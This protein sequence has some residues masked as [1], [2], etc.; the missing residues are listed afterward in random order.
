MPLNILFIS[1]YFP[2]EMGAPAARTYELAKHWVRSGHSVTVL[3]AF[4]HHP[5]GVIPKEYRK[6]IFLRERVE[7]IQV[8]R[9]F[10]YAT[11]NKGFLKRTLSYLSFMS[12]AILFSPLVKGPFQVVVAT[13][14]QFFVAVAGCFISRLKRRPFIFEVRDLWPESIVAVGALRNPAIIRLLTKIEFFLYTKASLIVGVAES[15]RRILVERGIPSSKIEIVPNG[16]D[17]DLFSHPAEGM[18]VRR[19]HHIDGKFIVSYIGTHGMAHALHRVLDA[20]NLLREEDD[21]HFLFVGE[22]A[23]KED[24]VR[25][26]AILALPNVT[27]LGQQ[28]HEAIPAFLS[29]SDVSLV[30]LRDAPL[31]S[32]VLPSKMFE[33]MGAGR[34]VI[35]GVRGEA[36]ELLERADAGLYVEPEDP[37]QLRD[38]ILRLYRDEAMRRRLGEN[39]RRFVLAHH[40]REHLAQRYADV[41]QTVADRS[42]S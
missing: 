29:A 35:L 34:P 41:L 5:T 27:F 15:T 18:E 8:V 3:T 42:A 2:P 14:P 12:S 37:Q 31:F 13:S 10:V 1:Q 30:S 33:I 19:Q 11:A 21:I 38:A 32:A 22:G 28:D 40:S 23:E 6:K 17:A 39:G 25:Y 24:L 36:R 16:V 20:A 7:G 26:S 9:S 4:P